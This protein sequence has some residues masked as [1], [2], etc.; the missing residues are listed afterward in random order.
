MRGEGEGEGDGE[1]EGEGDGHHL[2]SLSATQCLRPRFELVAPHGLKR[3]LNV[4]GDGKPVLGM[5]PLALAP[6]RHHRHHLRVRVRVRA[7]VG[8]RV[9]VRCED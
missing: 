7:S 6:A 2:A 3:Q 5:K 1:G 8:V 4:L 9:R